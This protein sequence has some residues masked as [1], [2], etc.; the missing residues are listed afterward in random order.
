DNFFE[1]G[2]HSLTAVRLT[3]RLRQGLGH[4]VSLRALFNHPTVAGI[5]VLIDGQE[6]V[7]DVPIA[8]RPAGLERMPLSPAQERLWFLWRLDPDSAAYTIAGSIRLEGALDADALRSA[9]AAVVAR[10]ESLRTR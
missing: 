6:A 8:P 4:D 2:G 10:H 9:A 7:A 5:A 3:A 1:I